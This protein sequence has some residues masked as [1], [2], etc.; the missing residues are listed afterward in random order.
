MKRPYSVPEGYFGRMEARLQR[1]PSEASAEREVTAWAKVKPYLCLVAVFAFAFVLKTFLPE[2][3]IDLE[4]QQV[5][6]EQLMFSDLIP[7][8]NPDFI[9]E[10]DSY[11][12]EVI[13][14]DDIRNYLINSNTS[15]ETIEYLLS[16]Y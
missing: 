8:S 6:Y 2:N 15:L 13:S 3:Q 11:Q 7:Q 4:D 10:L 5:T 1:I 9:F 14:E 16:C 12:D